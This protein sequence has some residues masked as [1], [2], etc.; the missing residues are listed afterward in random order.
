MT[1]DKTCIIKYKNIIKEYNNSGEYIKDINFKEDKFRLLKINNSKFCLV[2]NKKYK[3]FD[4][5]LNILAE[6]KI[7]DKFPHGYGGVLEQISDIG[8]F[9]SNLGEEIN[10]IQNNKNFNFKC[11]DINNIDCFKSNN[12]LI[13]LTN[14]KIFIFDIDKF[15]MLKEIPLEFMYY[16]MFAKKS[17]V[18]VC[19]FTN[20]LNGE[21]NQ[22]LI[23][24]NDLI[25]EFG[26]V[27]QMNNIK[28]SDDKIIFWNKDGMLLVDKNMEKVL[29]QSKNMGSSGE[30]ISFN[31][32]YI[33]IKENEIFKVWNLEDD[34]IIFFSTFEKSLN[35][36]HNTIYN[37]NKIFNLMNGNKVINI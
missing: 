3:V 13:I 2:N 18:L 20:L 14:Y 25:I 28:K 36:N 16:R 23:D 26:P 37:Y 6:F 32:K 22:I 1:L 33:M 12:K 4:N 5:D 7:D 35:I 29:L 21:L 8:I 17:N 10:I 30:N 31:K 11:K 27:L 9:Y 34:S 24:L 19:F 15:K